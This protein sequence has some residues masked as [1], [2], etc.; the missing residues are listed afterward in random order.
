MSKVFICKE[1]ND[2]NAYGEELIF[3]YA[4]RQDAL[5]HLAKRFKVCFGMTL[6]EYKAS[7]HSDTDVVTTDYVSIDTGDDGVVY[8]VVDEKNILP[9]ENEE[10]DNLFTNDNADKPDPSRYENAMAAS[11]KIADII[12]DRY[13][14]TFYDSVSDGFDAFVRSAINDYILKGDIG[15]ENILD[16]DIYRKPVNEAFE[17]FLDALT[18]R[19]LNK[20][21]GL[22]VPDKAFREQLKADIRKYILCASVASSYDKDETYDA[23]RRKLEAEWNSPDVKLSRLTARASNL[24]GDAIDLIRT[25]ESDKKGTYTFTVNDLILSKDLSFDNA[26]LALSSYVY[27]R[28]GIIL[29]EA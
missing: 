3:V 1:F 11:R 20:I 29:E 24:A 18:E 23:I 2:A 15:D 27:G 25:S 9:L 6:D 14:D 26:K 8:F 13:L 21:E 7:H 16:V 5:D 17:E 19:Q 10:E 28:T 22:P 4:K 12:A